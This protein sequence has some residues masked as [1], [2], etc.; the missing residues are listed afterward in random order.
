MYADDTSVTY[1]N[2]DPL[3]LIRV[4]NTDLENISEWMREN[5]LSLNAGKSEFMVIGNAK[6]LRQVGD[7]IT[8]EINGEDLS[9]VHKTKY[10][11][12]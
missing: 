5:K 8:C 2:S 7:N 6:Q 3:E 9:R 11:G 10:L 1:A 12:I 4:I